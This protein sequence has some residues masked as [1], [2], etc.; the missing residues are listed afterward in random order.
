MGRTLSVGASVVLAAAFVAGALVTAG[1]FEVRANPYQQVALPE[2]RPLGGA[3][4][5][6]ARVVA[7]SAAP[8]ALSFE[9]LVLGRGSAERGPISRAWVAVGGDHFAARYDSGLLLLEQIAQF[10]DPSAKYRAIAREFPNAK[11]I[12]LPSGPALLLRGN[13]PGRGP[14]IDLVAGG[15]N[16]QIQTGDGDVRVAELLTMAKSLHPLKDR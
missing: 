5:P 2:L 4:I 8:G 15:V 12:T 1:L 10:S 7:I 11:P 3:P 9:P 13:I 14:T 6:N 16:V